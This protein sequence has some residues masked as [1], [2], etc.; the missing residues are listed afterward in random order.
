MSPDELDDSD[1]DLVLP[2]VTSVSDDR[3]LEELETASASRRRKSTG[4]QDGNRVR[5]YTVTPSRHRRPYCGAEIRVTDMPFVSKYIEK[6]V[7]YHCQ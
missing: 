5:C 3:E 2:V 7:A 6:Q 1:T 4:V